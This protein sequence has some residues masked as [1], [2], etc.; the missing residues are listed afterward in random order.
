MNTI[1][2]P[3][4]FPELVI[5]YGARQQMTGL[6]DAGV[7]KLDAPG[8][9]SLFL[10]I[11][12]ANGFAEVPAEAERLRW[13]AAQGISCPEV[14]A[15]AVHGGRNWLL[16]SALPGKDLESA[17][18]LPAETT[19]AMIAG[20]LR[21]LHALDVHSCPFDHRLERRIADARARL[22]AGL[23]DEEDFDG[24]RLGQT[25]QQVFADLVALRP[26]SEDLVVTHGDACL[27]NLMVDGGRFSGFIDCGRLGVA[28]RCQDLALVCRSIRDDFGEEWIAP[29]LA[30]YGKPDADP[31]KLSYYQLLDEFF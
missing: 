11:D 25:A 8:K 18:P 20:A 5:G 3:L 26:T 22:E 9:S 14:L 23:I 15:F 2:L 16:M 31:A 28:D 19:I 10:K 6:S 27:P 4:P 7:F 30:L 21:T 13:L 24:E 1:P 12:D 17:G 29:F